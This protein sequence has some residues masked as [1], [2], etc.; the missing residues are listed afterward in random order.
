M[1]T[2]DLKLVRITLESNQE[3]QWF[4]EGFGQ[5]F[6]NRRAFNKQDGAEIHTISKKGVEINEPLMSKINGRLNLV[7]HQWDI[8]EVYFY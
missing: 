2:T 3:N 4:E 5:R 1:K 6:F 8:V 7:S